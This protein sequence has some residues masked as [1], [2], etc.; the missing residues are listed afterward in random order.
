[1]R[2]KRAP[3]LAAFLISLLLLSGC[4]AKSAVP[5]DSTAGGQETKAS[6]KVSQDLVIGTRANPVTLDPHKQ[7]DVSTNQ[8]LSPA[9]EGL[10]ILGAD[11]KLRGALAESWDVSQ[12]GIEI[13][14]KLRK[15]VK[16]HDGTPMD[17]EAVKFS[18]DRIKDPATKSP[19]AGYLADVKNI[20]VIDP[21][22]LK[23]SLNHIDVAFV[24]NLQ[25]PSVAIVSPTA[26]KAAGDNFAAK[27]VG[28]GPFMF[29]E[30]V[31]DN[32]L[33]YTKFKEYWGGEP[34]L[35]TVTIR[36]IPED[37]TRMVELE[38]GNIQWA[39]YVP[40]MEVARL[41]KVGLKRSEVPPNNQHMMAL[42]NRTGAFTDE[43][44]RKA[45]SYAIDRELILKEIFYGFGQV[46][47]TSHPKQSWAFN[48]S[49]PGYTYDPAKANQLLD[50][51]GWKK[52][53]DGVRVKDGKRL[54]VKMLTGEAAIRVQ[55]SQVVQGML[56]E[57]GI[58]SDI[59]T[60]EWGTYLNEMRAGNYEISYWDYYSSNFNGEAYTSS[61]HSK[62][63]WNVYFFQD[64]E[65]D[66]VIEQG[67]STT[68]MQARK[69][70]YDRYQQLL[71]DHAYVVFMINQTKVALRS[72]QL[73]DVEH[74]PSDYLLLGKAKFVAK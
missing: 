10:T 57:V 44:L 32:K 28:T 37:N 27:P 40:P 74:T 73:V 11:L 25:G 68:E 50:E 60:M 63:Y 42:N 64:Q 20:E 45:V 53:P 31:P 30:Y 46:A 9:F 16:F 69:A 24:T 26:V 59:V 70:A 12:D 52:G 62:D 67:L 49:I 5:A 41:E 29:K 1:M 13:T 19:G 47:T 23:V 65:V 72:P 54:K 51:A 55:V 17:A 15:N 7:R 43:R 18:L 21:L 58:D 4:G 56:R 39:A 34:N 35:D 36:P 3:G 8:A 66:K 2:F 22:T 6:P 14:F 38:A 61:F 33:V 71:N 48:A